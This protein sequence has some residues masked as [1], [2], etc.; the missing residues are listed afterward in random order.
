MSPGPRTWTTTFTTISGKPHAQSAPHLIGLSTRRD[1]KTAWVRFIKTY[2]NWTRVRE[3][4][5][6]ATNDKPRRHRSDT[7]KSVSATEFSSSIPDELR[8]SSGNPA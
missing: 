2:L 7:G 3:C 8:L 5:K 6:G 1:V 4:L